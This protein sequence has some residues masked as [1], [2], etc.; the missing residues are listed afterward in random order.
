MTWLAYLIFGVAILSFLFIAL[1][2]A[3]NNATSQDWV[4]WSKAVAIWAA[5]M[6]AAFCAGL[7]TKVAL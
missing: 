7:V 4:A 2:K 6:A 1:E 5:M 3:E